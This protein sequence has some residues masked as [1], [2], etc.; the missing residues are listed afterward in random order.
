M[1]QADGASANMSSHSCGLTQLSKAENQARGRSHPLGALLGAGGDPSARPVFELTTS[2]AAAP[3]M[4][5]NIAGYTI[6]GCLGLSAC[7]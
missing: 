1:S 2:G 5:A 4:D 7:S 3:T 6:P